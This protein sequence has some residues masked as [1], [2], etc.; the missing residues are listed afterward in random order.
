L[1]LK[2]KIN[3]FFC[4]EELSP[5]RK[6]RELNGGEGH[7]FLASYIIEKKRKCGLI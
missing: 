2:E 7:A 6:E 5:T 1:T 3:H 4:N